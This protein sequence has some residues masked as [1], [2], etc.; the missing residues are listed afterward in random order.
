MLGQVGPEETIL[1]LWQNT[2]TVVIGRNQNAWKEC[3]CHVLE[4]EGGQLARRL[5]GG[6]AVFHDLG[7]LNFTFIT[8]RES[9]DL[10]KQLSIILRAVR[11][12]GIDAEFSG[13]NDLVID[14]RKFSGNAFWL[15]SVS[16]YHHGTL[17]VNCDLRSL[18]RYLQVSREKIKSKGIDSVRSRVVNLSDVRHG[19]TVDIVS[20]AI[21][22]SFIKAYSG[23][24]R[25][26]EVDPHSLSEL[27]DLYRKYASW[28]WR[29]GKSPEFD[30]SYEKRF[31]WGEIELGMTLRKGHIESVQLFS[32]AMNADLI[33]T[34]ASALKQ[35]PLQITAIEAAL[36]NVVTSFN[37][38]DAR[39]IIEDVERWLRSKLLL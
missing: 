26:D 36:K 13:R 1:Y 37:D 11:S 34:I 12:L 20:D 17:L 9:Y 10:H 14:N 29:F 8:T 31:T 4:K 25:V 38:P 5:S 28:E 18:S 27:K 32:D 16:A 35:I 22:E 33:L 6:G 2:N 3:R 15:G 21:I 7:N 30:I 39:M 24:H 23:E 19:L